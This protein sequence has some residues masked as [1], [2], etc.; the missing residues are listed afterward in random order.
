MRRSRGRYSNASQAARELAERRWG[1]RVLDR[2][3]E[4]LVER[5]EQLNQAQRAAI[6]AAITEEAHDD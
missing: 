3:V 2:A 6:E 4:T 1:T 5:S